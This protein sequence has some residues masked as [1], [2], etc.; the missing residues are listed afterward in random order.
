MTIAQEMA[1]TR[2]STRVDVQYA[3]WVTIT[4]HSHEGSVHVCSGTKTPLTSHM[5]MTR[6]EQAGTR[7]ALPSQAP[8]MGREP[9]R[10]P[11][12]GQA[13]VAGWPNGGE[14]LACC[15]SPVMWVVG[16]L[17]GQ[18]CRSGELDARPTERKVP[19]N[20]S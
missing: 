9:D 16:G 8:V 2:L 17:G 19:E 12:L 1:Q 7:A 10:Q 20:P 18:T 11:G 15:L 14:T 5:P 4:Q 3:C 13:G 6:R